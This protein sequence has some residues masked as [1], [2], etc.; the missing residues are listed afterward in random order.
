MCLAVP[1][2]LV[3]LTGEG[4]GKVDSGGVKIDVSLAMLP[5]AQIG[6]YLIVHAGFGIEVL[7]E[8]EAAIRLDLFRELAAATANMEDA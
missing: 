8:Q 2:K 1:M 6:D 7:D 3:E 4:I 5:H